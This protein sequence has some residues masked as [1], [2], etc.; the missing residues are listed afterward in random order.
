MHRPKLGLS[1]IV[2]DGAATLR[3]CLGSVRGLV[4]EIVVADTGSTDSSPAIAREFGA[5]CLSIPW[6]NDFAAAR[7]T[8][9][10]HSQADWILWL[11]ADEELD[12][13]AAREIRP[14]LQKTHVGGYA[15]LIRNYLPARH[16]SV[17]GNRA[18]AND[19]RCPNAA[20]APAFAEHPVVRLFRRDPQVRFKGCVHENIA[21]QIVAA[22]WKLA[23]AKFCIHHLGFLERNHYGKKAEFYLELLRKKVEQEPSNPLA[24]LEL[25]RQLHEPFHKNEESLEC[26]ERALRLEP[27][28]DAARFLVGVVCLDMGR[29]E[30]A[31]A[32]LDGSRDEEYAVE[33]EH[34]RGD[35]LHNLGRLQ[36]A[37]TAYARG[38]QLA[39]HD[40]Q[41][42]SK[43]G[44]VEVRLGKRAGFARMQNAIVALP[45][46]AELHERLIR[47]CIAA[48]MLPEAAAAAEQFA[49]TVMHPKTILRAAAIRA[50]LKQDNQARTL[51]QRGLEFFP[52]SPELLQAKAELAGRHQT[53]GQGG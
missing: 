1:M 26:L 50:H 20:G 11:D 48:G 30:E 16:G 7:N 19:D 4:D 17:N 24:W 3:N 36:E 29:N 35:A 44:Y 43:L 6:E 27:K 34:C 47:A 33:R 14:L 8:A 18:Q 53:A 46:G 37:Q 39:G 10:G 15:S 25:A 9:L 2:R 32:A 28:L 40:P 42:D 13:A 23:K 22:G 45:Q 21:P 49:G 31:L 5:T 51:I 38:L 41:M 52:Q 12:S